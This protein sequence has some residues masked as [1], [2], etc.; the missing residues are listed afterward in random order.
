MGLGSFG[1]R[2]RF[3]LLK[4]SSGVRILG[5]WLSYVSDTLYPTCVWSYVESVELCLH[6]TI[7]SLGF[8][9]C[10]LGLAATPVWALHSVASYTFPVI[11]TSAA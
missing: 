10:F 11:V 8:K 2:S 6:L 5:F 3:G 9:A 7:S 1:V 4:G